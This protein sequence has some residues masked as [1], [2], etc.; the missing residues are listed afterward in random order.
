MGEAFDRFLDT[1]AIVNA[2]CA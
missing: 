1:S 2:Q